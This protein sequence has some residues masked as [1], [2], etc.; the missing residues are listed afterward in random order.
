[1]ENSHQIM[2]V[3]QLARSSIGKTM[4]KCKMATK[5]NEL[6]LTIQWHY[7]FSVVLAS[8]EKEFGTGFFKT[9]SSTGTPKA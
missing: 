9:R 8:N 1:M 7:E 4:L 2:A 5:N 6:V 3:K